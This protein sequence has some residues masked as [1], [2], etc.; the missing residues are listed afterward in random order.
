LGAVA[1]L[2]GWYISFGFVTTLKERNRKKKD[3]KD[4]YKTE[5]FK[6]H[7][8]GGFTTYYSTQTSHT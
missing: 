7:N 5:R 2:P 4:R 8:T 6:H 1:C 3:A